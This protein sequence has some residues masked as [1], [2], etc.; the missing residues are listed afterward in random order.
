M[1]A[2]RQGFYWWEFDPTWYALKALSWTGLIWDLK[3]VPQSV[4]VDAESQRRRARAA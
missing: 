1:G 3:P 2:A 4:Y